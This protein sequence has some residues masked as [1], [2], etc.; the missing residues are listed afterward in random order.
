MVARVL[1]G[2]AAAG[3]DVR[4]V[5]ICGCGWF[6]LSPDGRATV[7]DALKDI[8][9]Y[10]GPYFED[11]ALATVGLREADFA[12]IRRLLA[13]RRY[14]EARERVTPEMLR[15]AVVGDPRTAIRAIEHLAEAGVT[16]VSVGGPLGPDPRETVRLFGRQIIPH[17]RPAGRS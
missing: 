10:F 12:V 1:R 15:L 9:A 17:F 4:E 16:Q 6:S 5:D 11:A 7:T 2:V 8:V 14:E 3:R 13:A